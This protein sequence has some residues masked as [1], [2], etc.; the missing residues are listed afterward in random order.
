MLRSITDQICTE[1]RRFGTSPVY[2]SFDAVPVSKKD[3][4]IYTVV[5]IESFSATAPVYSPYIVY[6][7]FSTQI[8]I[9]LT[10]PPD[11]PLDEL[12]SYYSRTAG[13][14]I[15][16]MSGLSCRL[17]KLS[18]KYDSNICRLVLTAI[19][20]ATGITRIERSIE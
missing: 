8:S 13:I 6:I 5:G 9:K 14:A 4:G 3:K 19:F 1:L 11:C 15:S 16:E 17:E 10:A 18:A 20:S 7:P 12:Y 2:S